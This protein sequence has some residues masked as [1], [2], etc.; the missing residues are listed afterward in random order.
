MAC[1]IERSCANGLLTSD[2][3]GIG[4]EFTQRGESPYGRAAEIE[5]KDQEE[6]VAIE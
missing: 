4:R 5:P 1:G 2:A 6:E 3:C